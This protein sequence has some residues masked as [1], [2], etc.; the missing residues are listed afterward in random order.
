MNRG[1]PS[2]HRA[3]LIVSSIREHGCA[4]CVSR[5]FAPSSP[6]SMGRWDEGRTA[7][8]VLFPPFHT[9]AINMHHLSAE[10]ARYTKECDANNRQENGNAHVWADTGGV[11][12]PQPDIYRIQHDRSEVDRHVRQSN[13]LDRRRASFVVEQ[14]DKSRYRCTK[15]ADEAAHHAKQSR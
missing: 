6:H 9:H 2:A 12:H 5:K 13:P 4:A 1:T 15:G 3:Q 11:T 10:P 7:N 14:V 8:E